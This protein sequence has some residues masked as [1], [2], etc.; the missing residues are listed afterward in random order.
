MGCAPE[1]RATPE[2]WAAT[3]SSLGL[4]GQVPVGASTPVG[5][6]SVCPHVTPPRLF[7]AARSPRVID[8]GAAPHGRVGGAYRPPILQRQVSPPGT[9]APNPPHP[10]RRTADR[11]LTRPGDA[12]V[13]APVAPAVSVGVPRTASPGKR[14]R[15]SRTD[16]R[17]L[18]RRTR[19]PTPPRRNPLPHRPASPGNGGTPPPAP[20]RRDVRPRPDRLHRAPAVNRPPIPANTLAT[21]YLWRVRPSSTTLCIGSETLGT[22]GRSAHGHGQATRRQ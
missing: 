13:R 18:A 22:Q 15:P 17:A 8:A 16:R 2:L 9:R 6:R 5:V 3:G 7:V 19:R 20:E 4:G 12:F 11:L 1:G 14:G 21:P 10:G